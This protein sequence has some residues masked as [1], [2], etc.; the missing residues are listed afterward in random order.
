MIG[1][2][3]FGY[4]VVARIHRPRKV[5]REQLEQAGVIVCGDT[6]AQMLADSEREM[7]EYEV[8][9][10]L[11]ERVARDIDARIR[12]MDRVAVGEDG[13]GVSFSIRQIRQ[14]LRDLRDIAS[15]MHADPA[16]PSG[17]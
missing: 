15:K 10:A 6:E 16:A 11:Y 2:T 4:R 14:Y 17:G 3:L 1:F 7:H 9:T 8:L 5:T 12:D 13:T